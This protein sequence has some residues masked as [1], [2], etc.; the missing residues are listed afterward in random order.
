MSQHLFSITQESLQT[1][2]TRSALIKSIITMISIISNTLIFKQQ[3]YRWSIY[4]INAQWSIYKM[5]YAQAPSLL[6][7]LLILR[8]KMLGLLRLNFSTSL[9]RSRVLPGMILSTGSHEG[10][11][12]NSSGSSFILQEFPSTLLHMIC[13]YIYILTIIEKWFP[14]VRGP[15][16]TKS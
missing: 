7:V 8:E 9:L 14:V 11:L 12:Q 2:T 6:S 16:T 10:S 15:S 13:I 3:I 4:K 5:I 1:A